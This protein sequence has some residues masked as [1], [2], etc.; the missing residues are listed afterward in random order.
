MTQADVPAAD[1]LRERAGWNQ[2]AQDW[3]RFLDFE[4]DGCFVATEEGQV[5]GTVTTL[6][7][8]VDLAW[9]G[10]MLVD[11]DYRRRGIGTRLMQRA[12]K[13]L[14]G[15]GVRTIKLDATPAGQ[16]L[17]ERLGFMVESNLAR[18][19]RP[20]RADASPANARPGTTRVLE[21]QDWP[22]IE[23]LDQ[24][25]FGVRRVRFL[26][27]LADAGK[28]ARVWP[29]AGGISGWGF[30]RGGSQADYL[31]PVECQLEHAASILISTLL[32]G[33][34]HRAVFWDIPDGNMTSKK[35]AE[36]SGFAPVRPL[37]RM[38]LGTPLRVGAPETLYAISCPATG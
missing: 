32:T 7:Y 5:R 17:Y 23:A 13:H 28:G 20:P 6:R 21:E 35:I 4:P 18:W 3:H 22:A 2:T 1:R 8:G 30:L 38:R 24:A 10:M 37:A 36:N 15:C 11:P 29:A 9:I 19:H 14:Q 34:D 31:G 33:S 16:P 12:L 27:A 25:A 26:R